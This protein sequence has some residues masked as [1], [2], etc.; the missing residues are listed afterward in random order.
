M[1]EKLISNYIKTMTIEDI[2][3]FA[4]KKNISITD[5]DSITIYNFLKDN[6]KDLYYGNI[7]VIKDKLEG[8]IDN[9]LYIKLISL[10]NEERNKYLL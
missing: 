3:K 2:K 8:K 5:K 4:V 10:Y 7:K 9:N 1:Y 6:Y